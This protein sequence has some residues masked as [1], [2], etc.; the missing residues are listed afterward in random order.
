MSSDASKLT[1]TGTNAAAKDAGF[2]NFQN[3]L[4][5]YGLK[6]WNNDDVEEGKTILRAMGYGV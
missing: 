3:F 2:Q 6:I 5:S 4:Q 1:I